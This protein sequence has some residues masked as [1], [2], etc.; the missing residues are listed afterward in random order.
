MFRTALLSVWNIRQGLSSHPELPL[1]VH[2][3]GMF[4]PSVDLVLTPWQSL[5]LCWLLAQGLDLIVL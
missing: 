2:W 1:L 5:Q 3:A 4:P